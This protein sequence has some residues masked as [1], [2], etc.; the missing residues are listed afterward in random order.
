[1]QQAGSHFLREM[2][3]SKAAR[4]CIYTVFKARMPA[5]DPTIGLQA[6]KQVWTKCKSL[7]APHCNFFQILLLMM[8]LKCFNIPCSPPPTRGSGEERLWEKWDLFTKVLWSNSCL[9]CLEI[10]SSV[11]KSAAAA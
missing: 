1:M 2:Q 10:G 3:K 7:E 11:H 8:V 9:C 5:K 6:N 4:K